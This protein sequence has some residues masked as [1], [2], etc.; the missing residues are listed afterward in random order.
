MRAT[1]PIAPP[2]IAPTGVELLTAA[3]VPEMALPVVEEGTDDDTEDGN[4]PFWTIRKLNERAVVLGFCPF[5]TS[6]VWGPGVS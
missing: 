5:T 2:T 3:D 1:P 6:N 4:V